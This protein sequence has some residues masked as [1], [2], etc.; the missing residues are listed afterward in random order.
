MFSGVLRELSETATPPLKSPRA[1][2]VSRIQGFL[3][4]LWAIVYVYSFGSA[5]IY[6][7]VIYAPPASC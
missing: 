2:A 4:R 1:K 6:A 7:P 3:H 5:Y